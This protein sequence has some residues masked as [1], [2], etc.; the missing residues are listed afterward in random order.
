[1]TTLYTT[2]LCYENFWALQKI[3]TKH[4]FRLSRSK[5]KNRRYKVKYRVEMEQSM[6]SSH[7]STSNEKYTLI[8][9]SMENQSPWNK[10]SSL[11]FI[12][13][14]I[15]F[16]G[17]KDLTQFSFHW[18]S[19]PLEWRKQPCFSFHGRILTLEWN[20]RYISSLPGMKNSFL[21][22]NSSSVRVSH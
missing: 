9:Y 5:K 21:F 2:N 3:Y 4:G 22:C 17:I 7:L 11:S 13:W 10:R 6:F 18:I 12:P 14:D 19:I 16:L 8:L 15:T 20:C 1:M